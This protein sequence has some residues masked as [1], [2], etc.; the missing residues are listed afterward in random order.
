VT[1]G[2]ITFG[3]QHP[4]QHLEVSNMSKHS[5]IR[6]DPIGGED[7]DINNDG[8]VDI[9]DKYLKAKRD[10]FKRY[11]QARKTKTPLQV[12]AAKMENNMIKLMGLVELP[13]VGSLKEEE[14]WIQKAIEKPGALHKQLGVPAGEKIP[15]AD[16]KAA[17]EKGGKLGKRAR[18]AMTLKKLKEEANL[19]EEQLAK[20]NGMLEAL[21]PVGQEDADIDNDGDV[22]SSDKYLK[23]R[24]DAIG[25][26][27]QKEGKENEDHE[28]SMA[29]KTLDSII[30]HATEL[31]G[32]IG[33]EEK[34]IPAWIQDHIAVAEN[35]LD[36]ANTSYHEY[37]QEEKTDKPVDQDMAAMAESV[38]EVA[39]EGWEKTVLAM[40]KHKEIDNPW[41]LAHW[42]KK[43]G[44]HPKKEEK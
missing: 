15:A 19:T 24:R 9:S 5:H 4:P 12:P 40:K 41:A 1:T 36:Q 26:A 2:K 42:M 39:P 14:K 13:A 32:K 35:N 29:T 30:R 7:S 23:N 44:Y 43:K 21:D 17:A 27:M 18:L 8:K 34:D 3:Q 31:K 22:D 28:V 11:M 25:K 33:M 20:I 6:K 16:L 37:G 38:S 10:L